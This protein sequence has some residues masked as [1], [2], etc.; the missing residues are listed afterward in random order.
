MNQPDFSN[1]NFHRP[2][3]RIPHRLVWMIALLVGFSLAWAI[4][5][6]NLI[7]VIALVMIAILGWASSY[8]WRK[9]LDVLVG[10]LGRLRKL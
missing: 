5:P 4:L 9:A 7:F 10:W 1:L 8:G 2:K 3:R 6:A